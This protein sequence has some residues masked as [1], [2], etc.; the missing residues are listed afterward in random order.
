MQKKIIMN[1]LRIKRLENAIALIEKAREIVE[2]VK[3]EEE[4]VYDNLPEELQDSERGI[5]MQDTIDNLFFMD[6][7]F[8][9]LIE[10]LNDIVYP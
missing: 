2:E 8:Y 1:E 6:D 3:D 5:M 10:S 4:Y 7:D 9:N